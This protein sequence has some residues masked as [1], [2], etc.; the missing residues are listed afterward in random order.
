MTK[1]MQATPFEAVKIGVVSSINREKA[2]ARVHFE[3]CDD[4]V[5]DELSVIPF[6]TMKTKHYWMPCVGEMVICLF[7]ANGPETGF[8]IGSAYSEADTPPEDVGEKDCVGIWF[9]DGTIIKYELETN[10]LVLDCVGEINIVAKQPITIKAESDVYLDGSLHVTKDVVANGVSLAN[11]IHQ[12][13]S[14]TTSSPSKG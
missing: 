6:R 8:I 9:E 5:S 13:P 1:S 3:D 7:A 12:A 10:T 11:H 14:G 2:T 4:A